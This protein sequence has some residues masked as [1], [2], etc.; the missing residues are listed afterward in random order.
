MTIFVGVAAQATR[1]RTSVDPG[2][3][4]AAWK[5]GCYKAMLLTGAKD[6]AT[7]RF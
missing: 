6:P 1:L 7:L 5:A 4:E 3:I 2:A